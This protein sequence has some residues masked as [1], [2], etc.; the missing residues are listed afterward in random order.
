MSTGRRIE[1]ARIR[2]GIGGFYYV[3]AAGAVYECRARGIFRKNGITPLAGDFVTVELDGADPAGGNN[4][5]EAIAPR[6]NQFTRPPVANIDQLFIVV[7]VVKPR[8]NFLLID[9]L[10]AIAVYKQVTPVIVVTKGDL[11]SAEEIRRI[12]HTTGIRTIVSDR[13]ADTAEQIRTLI[14]GKVSAF[15]G[16]SGVGKSTLINLIAPE[17]ELETAHISEKLGRGR[18]TTRTAELF[19]IA[20]GYVV[21]TPGFSSMDFSAGEQIPREELAACFPEFVPFLSQ[22]RFTSCSHTSDQGC[23]LRRPLEKGEI[24]PSRHDSYVQLYQEVKGIRQWQK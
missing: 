20:G 16:N 5:I 6:R 12:Y 17:L 7:S 2:K 19:P 18:H 24:A 13:D 23:G 14:R 3:E 9:R 8:P 4:T 11:A 21:D 15:T 1:H 22:C 10:S